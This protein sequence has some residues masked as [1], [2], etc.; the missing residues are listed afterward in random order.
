MVDADQGKVAAGNADGL[1]IEGHGVQRT[2]FV[3]FADWSPEPGT[4]ILLCTKCF[5]T[6]A[7]LDRLEKDHE[8]IPVQNGFDATLVGRIT[9]EGIASYVSECESDRPFT[10]ITRD[11][12]LHLG[13]SSRDATG[14]SD[15]FERLAR[16]LD[17]NG[18]FRV[19]RVEDVRPYKYSKLMYNAAISPLAAVSG[20]DNAQ[21]L[22]RPEARAM[23]FAFLRENYSILRRAKITLGRIGPFHPDTVNRILNLPLIARVMAP[24][25]AR[26]LRN[27]YCSMSGDIEKGRTE[28]EHFNGHLVELAGNEPCPM[29]R[30]ACSV[31]RRMESAREQPNP[32]RLGELVI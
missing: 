28:I 27:T 11:G 21:L 9:H 2:S 23:F 19:V 16:D 7:V 10:R 1:E 15:V 31:V 5:D 13:P 26:S 25:F 17:A 24:S 22:T 8:I 6:P 4:P 14:G 12:D 30:L 20:L 29:N 32:D 18:C 3:E